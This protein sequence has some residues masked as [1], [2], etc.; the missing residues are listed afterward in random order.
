LSPPISLE[1]LAGERMCRDHKD[2]VPFF[3]RDI[4][5]TKIPPNFCLSKRL[6]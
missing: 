2:A 1:L 3:V 6:P 5:H 4:N